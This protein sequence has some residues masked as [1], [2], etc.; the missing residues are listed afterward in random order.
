MKPEVFEMFKLAL[1]LVMLIITALVIPTAKKW[2]ESNMSKNQQKEALFWT[3]VA[4][5]MAEEIFKENGK[6]KVKKK[7]VLNW[8]DKNGIELTEEQLSALIEVVVSEF[9]ANGWSEPTIE[10]GV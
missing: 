3:K 8:L 6:G 9:K 1:Q 2:I 5:K 7:Y 10:Q 4:V